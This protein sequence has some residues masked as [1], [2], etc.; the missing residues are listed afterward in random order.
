MS[1]KYPS[2]LSFETQPKRLRVGVDASSWL[3]IFSE[4]VALVP[5]E[6]VE[7]DEGARYRVTLTPV[8]PELR[9]CPFCGGKA[10]VVRIYYIG[11]EPVAYRVQCCECEDG[12]SGNYH[13]KAAARAAWNRRA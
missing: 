6:D 5:P 4:V 13:T 8:G 9:P 3:S 10:E 11:N 12:Q 7:L 1:E 2:E